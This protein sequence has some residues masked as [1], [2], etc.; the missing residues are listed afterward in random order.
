LLPDR[1]NFLPAAVLKEENNMNESEYQELLEASWRRPLTPDELARVETWLASRPEAQMEWESESRLN[2][3]LSRLPDAPVASN[4]TAQVMQAIDRD[5]R[6]VERSPAFS[7]R[8][9][10]WFRRP[11]PR[12]AWAL[13]LVGA[14]W[15]GYERHQDNVRGEVATG[16]SVLANVANLSDPS[17]LQDFEAIQRLSKT[18]PGADDELYAVLIQ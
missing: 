14:L 9:R 16:I 13:L 17:V 3:L 7:E 8:I 11:A 4:F 1:G 5:A 10:R 6:A 12:I 18:S 2:G 15:F